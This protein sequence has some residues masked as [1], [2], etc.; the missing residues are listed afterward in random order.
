[1][2]CL[3]S[4]PAGVGEALTAGWCQ[5]EVLKTKEII[6]QRGTWS[7]LSFACDS[8]SL[9]RRSQAL[10]QHRTGLKDKP[11]MALHATQPTLFPHVLLL[12][13][14]LQQVMHWHTLLLLLWL[15]CWQC[16]IFMTTEWKKDC[17]TYPIHKSPDCSTETPR[18]NNKLQQ[19][20]ETRSQCVS[21]KWPSSSFHSTGEKPS[22][23]G[24]LFSSNLVVQTRQVSICRSSLFPL[25][26]NAPS[27]S[28]T[29][30][31]PALPVRKH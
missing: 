3:V 29:G 13:K 8:G 27:T 7:V 4:S 6:C 31:T 2:R 16:Q 12:V 26:P 5:R 21:V 28:P 1:M 25:H 18:R 9:W 10:I 24:S 22:N 30:P 19:L 14:G 11:L 23:Y 15:H 20:R 17:V